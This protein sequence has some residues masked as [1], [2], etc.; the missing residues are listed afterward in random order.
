MPEEPTTLPSETPTKSWLTGDLVWLGVIV[1]AVAVVVDQ[2]LLVR[3]QVGDNRALNC[4]FTFAVFVIQIGIL[5]ALVGMRVKARPYWWGIFVWS[6]LL[7]DLQVFAIAGPEGVW[8]NPVKAFGF[9]FGSAQIGVTVCWGL[10]GKMKWMTRI[11]I[12]ADVAKGRLIIM[13]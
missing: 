13:H 5:S 4:A 2:N 6:I 10:L 1:P 12:A 9:A 8:Q 3:C 11:P 7:V